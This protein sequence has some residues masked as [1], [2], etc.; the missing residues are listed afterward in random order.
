MS[1]LNNQRTDDDSSPG[2]DDGEEPRDK[3]ARPKHKNLLNKND[4]DKVVDFDP[5][6]N[7][8]D[9]MIL[10]YVVSEKRAMRNLN[11]ETLNNKL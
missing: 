10:D 8:V 4:F 3:S 7:K 5:V 6:S 1:Q 11:R 2:S 9:R